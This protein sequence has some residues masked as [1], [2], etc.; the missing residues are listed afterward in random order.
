MR[1]RIRKQL[2][3]PLIGYIARGSELEMSQALAERFVNS[4]YAEYVKVREQKESNEQQPKAG[5]D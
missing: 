5:T 3:V 1:I 4:T 2:F